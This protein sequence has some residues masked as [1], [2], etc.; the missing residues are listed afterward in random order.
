MPHKRPSIIAAERAAGIFGETS[1]E[2]KN[3]LFYLREAVFCAETRCKEVRGLNP[4][5]EP[6]FGGRISEQLAADVPEIIAELK[7]ILLDPASSVDQKIQVG[8][9]IAKL[10]GRLVDREIS[11]RLKADKAAMIAERR[12]RLKS[13]EK[14]TTAAATAAARRHIDKQLKQHIEEIRGENGVI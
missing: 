9:V 3:I 1:D 10:Q 7:R 12:T 2:A 11:A 13:V 4:K 5:G 8:Q 14:R 6:P